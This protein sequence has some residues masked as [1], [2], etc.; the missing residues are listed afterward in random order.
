MAVTT[1]RQYLGSGAA[2]GVGLLAAACDVVGSLGGEVAPDATQETRPAIAKPPGV[3]N[4]T[5]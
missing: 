2:L 3:P 4:Q 1:R 5:K